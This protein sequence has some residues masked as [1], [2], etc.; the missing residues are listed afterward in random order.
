MRKAPIIIT[1]VLL[2]CVFGTCVYFAGG[3]SA[4]IPPIRKYNYAGGVAQFR[5]AVK[6]F[7]PDKL[8]DYN[9]TDDNIRE[10]FIHL[11]KGKDTLEY[12]ILCDQTDDKD[13]NKGA[14]IQL[15]GAF[16]RNN[17]FVGGYGIKA[18][19]MKQIL[20][21]FENDYLLELKK[22]Q[23]VVLIPDTAKS[24]WDKFSIY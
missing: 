19:G 8:S 15:V 3:V 16:K 1:V 22:K 4:T 7:K 21:D 18:V 6:N 24:F 2:I 12:N 23:G 10:M 14:V 13:V 11:R 9:V 5:K 17:S 20:Y